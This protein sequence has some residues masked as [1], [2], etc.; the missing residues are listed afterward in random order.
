[1]K[2]LI[3]FDLYGTLV[4]SDV[5]DCEIRP[6]FQDLWEHYKKKAT[7]IISTDGKTLDVQEI[8]KKTKLKDKFTA[9][10]DCEHLFEADGRTIKD[11]TR[12]LLDHST[13]AKNSVFI[14][15][16]FLGCDECSA[17]YAKIPF[18][19]VPQFRL[20]PP[21]EY[22]KSFQRDW[23]IYE[24]EDNPFTFKSLIGRI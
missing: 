3:I 15:D 4:K 22:I 18:I 19:Q 11:L 10:Y 9:V 8:L 14:G 13:S 7:F 5:E 16:N 24:S 21:S 17:F 12:I 2:K 1:M 6:G 20:S 23:T